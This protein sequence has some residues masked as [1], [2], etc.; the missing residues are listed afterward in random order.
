MGLTYPLLS[1]WQTKTLR[2]YGILETQPDHPIY[3]RTRRAYM[4]IDKDGIVRWTKI[5]ADPSKALSDDEL[6]AEVDKVVAKPCF[7]C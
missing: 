7:S 6:L 4:L 5:L 1:D 3:W 2:A